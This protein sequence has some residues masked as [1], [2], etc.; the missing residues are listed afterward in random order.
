MKCSTRLIRTRLVAVA[1][2][3]C[4]LGTVCACT[5]SNGHGGDLLKD[6]VKLSIPVYIDTFYEF[7]HSVADRARPIAYEMGLTSGGVRY[8]SIDLPESVSPDS[9]T[10]SARYLWA[11]LSESQSQGFDF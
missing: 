3:V 4:I 2:G 7:A 9:D 6:R 8:F 5:G 1:V 11:K 10:A